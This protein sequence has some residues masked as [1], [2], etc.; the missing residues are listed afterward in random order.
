MLVESEAGE[1]PI[2]CKGA[3]RRLERTGMGRPG[4]AGGDSEIGSILEL[5]VSIGC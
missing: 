4:V 1:L 5:R 2:S 3:G